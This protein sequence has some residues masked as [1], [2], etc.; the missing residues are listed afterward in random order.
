MDIRLV[1]EKLYTQNQFVCP[2]TDERMYR[3]LETESGRAAVDEALKPF[4]RK[5]CSLENGGAFYIDTTDNVNPTDTSQ[6]RKQF[7]K[8]RDE[9]QPIVE[10]FVYISR[11]KPSVGILTSGQIIR[12]SE[13]LSLVTDNDLNTKH[14]AQ[15]LSFKMFKTSKQTTSEKLQVIFERLVKEGLLVSKNRS[16]MLYQVT[17]KYDYVQDIMQFII[18]RENIVIDDHKDAEQTGFAI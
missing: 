7:E 13:I 4:G 8:I 16:E 6:R 18:D 5:V 11:V 14:L 3:Y 2:Y 10:F 1:L 17:G 9:L 12:F 15:L